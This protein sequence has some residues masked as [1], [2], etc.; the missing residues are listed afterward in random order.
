MAPVLWPPET[1]PMLTMPPG[2]LA[3][4]GPPLPTEAE[5]KAPVVAVLKLP[6]LDDADAVPPLA[7]ALTV[8][9]VRTDASMRT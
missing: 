5:P 4:A 3:V 8:V 1:V 7:E 6:P 9:E 2:A